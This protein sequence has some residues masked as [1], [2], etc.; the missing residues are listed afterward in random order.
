MCGIAGAFSIGR[1]NK[2]QN[3]IEKIVNSQYRRGP[4]HQAIECIQ[5]DLTTLILG[6]NRLSIIDLSSDANQ[7]MWSS[8][9]YHCVVFNGEI[10]N[11]LELRAELTSLGHRFSTRSDTEVIIEAF[12][13]WGM[14][15]I[16]RF[17]GMFALALFDVQKQ[18]LW[19]LRD[20]FGVKPLYYYLSEDTLLFAST[21]TIIA[22]CMNLE[23]N[24]DYVSRGLTHWVYEDDGDISPYIGLKTLQ[25]AHY[26]EVTV[27]DAGKFNWRLYQYYDLTERMLAVKETLAALSVQ[28]LVELVTARLHEAVEIRLRADVPVGV[29]LSG[30]LDSSALAALLAFKHDDVIGFTF[31]HPW[32][33]QSEGPLVQELSKQIGIKVEYVWPGMSEIIQSFWDTLDAQG[34][35]FPGG[36]TVAQNLVYRAARAQGVK[37]LLGGQ[38]GDELFMGYRK[39][40][41]FWLHRLVHQKRYAEALVFMLSIVPMLVAERSKA[42]MYWT[43]RYRF[44]G[45]H[46]T[47]SVLRL[48]NPPRLS[49]GY[50]PVQPLW[51]RQTLD[52]TR[53]SLPTLLRYEDRNSMGN[54]VESRLPF[55]DYRLVELA[56]ALPEAVKVRGG[57]G[58]WIVREAIRGKI[59]EKI[60]AARYKRNFDV[61][62]AKWIERGLGASIRKALQERFATV[63]KWLKPGTKIEEAFSNSQLGKSPIAFTEAITLLWLGDHIR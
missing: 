53:W 62:E 14:S 51:A 33:S 45:S 5:S 8:D 35:P 15:A 41:M 21:G 6:H 9:R 59:P 11:Y 52:V 16:E 55:L 17:N 57:Y 23:P 40:S 31:G 47:D 58:K 39:F 54:S 26:L 20:R 34:A 30:G 2:W 19:L 48:P 13:E 4:D 7:P 28:D 22:K 63:Q 29:S 25:P 12:K 38:G 3:T 50:N 46:S 36:S 37:V 10:Y 24:L 56:L 44:T 18:M 61:E 43:Y 42:A 49:L 27:S 1:S 60:R 32:A